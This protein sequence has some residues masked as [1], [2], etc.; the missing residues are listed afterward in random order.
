[1]KRSLSVRKICFCIAI[2]QLLYMGMIGLSDKLFQGSVLLLWYLGLL[3]VLYYYHFAEW[4]LLCKL[5]SLLKLPYF[6]RQLQPLWQKVEQFSL[7]VQNHAILFATVAL[8]VIVLSIACVLLASI[9]ILLLE[10]YW[11]TDF[12][13]GNSFCPILWGLIAFLMKLAFISSAWVTSTK[14]EKMEG[15]ML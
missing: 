14:E 9:S 3:I 8:I 13:L 7:Q 11:L 12:S 1:M 2:F 15:Q 6:S 10:V 4:K 5:F